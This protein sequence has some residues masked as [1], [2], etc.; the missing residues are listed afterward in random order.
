LTKRQIDAIIHIRRKK[1]KAILKCKDPR[2]NAKRVVAKGYEES[3]ETLPK[4]NE[5]EGANMSKEMY[6]ILAHL[7]R[8]AELMFEYGLTGYAEDVGI[9]MGELEA[10]ALELE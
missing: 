1:S 3:L 4:L 9:L 8:A 6:E 5:R 10:D 2:R 7:D